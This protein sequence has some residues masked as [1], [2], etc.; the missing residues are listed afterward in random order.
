M[1][2]LSHLISEKNKIKISRL[3]SLSEDDQWK[4]KI[5]EEISLIKKSLVEVEFEE[6]DLQEILDF[7]CTD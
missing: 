5:I 1:A 7:I 6:K 3:Y 2:N 4:I